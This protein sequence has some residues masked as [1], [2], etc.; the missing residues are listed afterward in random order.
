MASHLLLHIAR[1]GTPHGH[2]SWFAGKRTQVSQKKKK[3]I[4]ETIVINGTEMPIAII[5]PKLP[6][7]FAV[8]WGNLASPMDVVYCLI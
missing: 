6:T 2:D 1:Q 7:S 8:N 4:I 3:N 5:F